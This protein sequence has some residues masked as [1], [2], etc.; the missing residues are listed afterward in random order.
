MTAMSEITLH[1]YV[2]MGCGETA[3]ETAV[4]KFFDSSEAFELAVKSYY[5][6]KIDLSPFNVA[7]LRWA[8][9]FLEMTKGYSED[10]LIQDRKGSSLAVF[11]TASWTLLQH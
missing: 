5:R 11:S 6:V 1:G 8:G 7:S 4:T 9:E 2:N 10:N 3:G